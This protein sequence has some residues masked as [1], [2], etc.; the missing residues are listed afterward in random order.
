[1]LLKRAGR[2]IKLHVLCHHFPGL[3]LILPA[4]R[5]GGHCKR[6]PIQKQNG[7][8]MGDT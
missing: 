3:T 5:N 7:F 2:A 4:L 1:M 8:I 6:A